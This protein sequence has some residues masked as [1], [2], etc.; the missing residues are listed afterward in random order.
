METNGH[1]EDVTLNPVN[2][3]AVWQPDIEEI[4]ERQKKFEKELDNVHK[5]LLQLSFGKDCIN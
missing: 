2:F 5:N 1:K 4:I 3:K